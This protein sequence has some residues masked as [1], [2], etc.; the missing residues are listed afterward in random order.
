MFGAIR[1]SNGP[2]RPERTYMQTATTN[3]ELETMIGAAAQAQRAYAE[4]GQEQVD[5]I[6]RRAAFAA[7]DARIDLAR[8]AASETGM[9]VMEDK[10][11]K[12]HFAAE[13]IYNNY[14][15]TRTCGVIERDLSFGIE[16]IAEPIGVLAGIVPTTNPTATAIF[17]ALLAL[18][19]RNA[20]IFSPHPRAA[21]LH[22][23]GGPDHP[24]GRC[25]RRCAAGIDRLH[26]KTH[27]RIV[28]AVDAA[29]AHQPDPGH[30]RPGHGEG[31]V[32]LR[33]TCHRRR[34]RQHPGGH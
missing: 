34:R 2:G 27:R 18:K 5:E 26:R 1:W 33:Q 6:F 25:G 24:R 13:Y 12:N 32:F 31:G 28:P 3:D 4:F 19:T 9:G 15:N 21:A 7:N 11:I 16:K 17:K 30:G 20:I 23:R 22:R 29:S 8:L 10:V 14:K